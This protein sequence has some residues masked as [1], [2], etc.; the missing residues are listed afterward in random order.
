MIILMV[1]TMVDDH[2]DVFL[3]VQHTGATR[4]WSGMVTIFIG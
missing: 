2:F 4:D 1:V 3:I